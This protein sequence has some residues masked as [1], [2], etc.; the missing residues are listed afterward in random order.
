MSAATAVSAPCWNALGQESLR[1]QDR[2]P[3]DD[4]CDR[5]PAP[6][7]APS[8]AADLRRVLAARGDERRHGGDVIGIGGVA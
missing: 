6:H 1:E 5:V 4:E 7:Q 3:E 8:R 2:N